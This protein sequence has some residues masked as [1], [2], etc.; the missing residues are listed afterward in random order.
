MMVIAG[1]GPTSAAGTH[2][3]SAVPFGT[4]VAG[5]TTYTATVTLPQGE[6][7]PATSTVT[8]DRVYVGSLNQALTNV[9]ATI[10]TTTGVVTL[11]VPAAI[12]AVTNANIR[13]SA[14]ITVQTIV[15]STTRHI[16]PADRCSW[17]QFTR[18]G[19]GYQIDNAIFYDG[20]SSALI[21]ILE[22][23]LGFIGKSGRFVQIAD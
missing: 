18:E 9:S 23:E 14:I 16:Y 1:L 17:D 11:V 4:I 19:G 13:I 15:S 2:T 22:P 21:R 10:N 3:F 6:T 20:V 7:F 12:A 5:T 8:V